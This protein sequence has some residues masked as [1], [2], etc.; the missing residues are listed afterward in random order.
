MIDKPRYDAKCE[1]P[2]HAST[3]KVIAFYL[4]QFH[5]IPENDEAWGKGFTEWT[6]VKKA[7]PLFEGHYQP[8]V[9]LNGNYYCLLDDGV[10]EAQAQMAKK[11]GIYG[12][13]YYHYYFG[14]GKKLLEK[15]LERMLRNPNVDIPFCLSWD[16]NDWSRKYWNDG[17]DT[18]I[19]AQDC[20][21]KANLDRHIDYLCEFFADSRYIKEDGKPLFI[22]YELPTIPRV[23]DRF[24]YVRE[25]VKANGFPG[26]II[27]AQNPSYF[28]FLSRK[29][30]DL[31]A[32]VYIQSEPNWA[33][34]SLRVKKL[35]TV[36]K[37]KLRAKNSLK[38]L[39]IFMGFM[40]TMRQ[41]KRSYNNLK[42]LKEGCYIHDYAEV[43]EEI[44]ADRHEDKRLIA[45]AFQDYDDTPR[46][47]YG[48]VFRGVSPE[49]FRDYMTRLVHKVKNEYAYPY[50]FFNAWNEW[51]EG[52]YLEPDERYGY[53]YLEALRDALNS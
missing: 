38:S 27:A 23:R 43:W 49:K 36:K 4:P 34:S 21:D 26:I 44:L 42:T 22:V 17:D 18:I 25:R 37:M 1:Q 39:L 29:C 9:P 30:F 28:D 20:S 12:F 13:C 11:Y 52:M 33:S 46:R 45:G 40:H 5:T 19:A 14:H 35:S 10:M 15:P 8:K 6:N 16:N 7:V 53:A 31:C 48:R 32:D 50:I 51:G 2:N 47:K 24:Q 41:V 3:V